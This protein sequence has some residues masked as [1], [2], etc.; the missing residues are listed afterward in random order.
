VPPQAMSSFW[1]S[2]IPGKP[3]NEAPATCIV[4]VPLV[5]ESRLSR[6]QTEGESIERCG[7]FESSALLLLVLL[8]R[9]TQLFEPLSAPGIGPPLL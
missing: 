1:P 4:P 2:K 5:F 7:S 6:Y 3:A 9:T 8:G